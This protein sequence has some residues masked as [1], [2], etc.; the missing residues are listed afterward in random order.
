MLVV[1]VSSFRPVQM[2]IVR[3][4]S[5]GITRMSMSDM[6]QESLFK[7]MMADQSMMLLADTSISEEEVLSVAGQATDLPDPLFAVGIAAAIFLGVAILQFSL[8]DLT[9][10]VTGFIYLVI[11]RLDDI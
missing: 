9:K 1:T 11:C 8:G 3:S 4:Y 7:H 10:E 2:N 5:V 6:I